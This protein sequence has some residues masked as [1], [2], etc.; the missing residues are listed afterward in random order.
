ME[1]KCILGTKEVTFSITVSGRD[2]EACLSLEFLEDNGL[3][4]ATGEEIIAWAKANEH[5]LV[6]AVNARAIGGVSNVRFNGL[7][8]REIF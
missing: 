7:V 1:F 4:A 8:L 2:F 5:E 6:R 3:D